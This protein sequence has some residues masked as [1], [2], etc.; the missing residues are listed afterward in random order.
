[1]TDSPQA[2]APAAPPSRLSRP[3]I[4]TVV[5][6]HVEEAGMLRLI[7]SVLVRAP[8]VR[9]L[10]LG[11]LD[12]RIAAHLDGVRVAGEG[13]AALA[14]AALERVDVGSVFTVL[15]GAIEQR[16]LDQV[17]KMVAMLDAVPDVA[18]RA[19]ASAVGW[20]SSVDLRG[21]IQPWFDAPEASLTWLALAAC[22]VHRVD[23]GSALPRLAVHAGGVRIRARALQ[24]AGELGRTD[25]R[26]ACIDS[27][28]TT[29]DAVPAL[30]AARAALLLGDRGRA[31]AHVHALALESSPQQTQAAALTMLFGDA[32]RGRALVGEL[33]KRAPTQASRRRLLIKC[34]GWSGDPKVV[35]WLIQ[36]M[37]DLTVAR[38]AG[39]AFTTITGADL[40]KL[41]LENIHQP[42]APPSGPNDDP[43]DDDVSMD[44][45]DSLP[46]PNVDKITAWWQREAARFAPGVRHLMGERIDAAS[47]HRVLE[48]GTQ[49][50]RSQAAH[51]RCA[52]APGTPLFNVAAP[53]WR[54]VRA[55]KTTTP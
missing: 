34:S 30:V 19:A 44:K 48:E 12:E 28:D 6:Q 15:V 18:A 33:A 2:T 43:D 51:L 45:D 39:E 25:L 47:L 16:D 35:P 9:L 31:L 14:R 42:D 23:P 4:A 32:D 26:D 29:K 54:Q 10:Q 3:I 50:V 22:A 24:A 49:R 27:L 46:W 11:R 21:L 37:A 8:H 38:L 55:L 52:I 13:G 7:R 41:D 36:Q 40:A 5:S 53:Q 20:V 17:T 1:M